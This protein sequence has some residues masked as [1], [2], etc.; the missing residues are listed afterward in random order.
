M[1]NL[2]FDFT[3]IVCEQ[4]HWYYLQYTS[5]CINDTSY[6]LLNMWYKKIKYLIVF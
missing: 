3:K 2:W 4:S 5:T 6:D 1:Y